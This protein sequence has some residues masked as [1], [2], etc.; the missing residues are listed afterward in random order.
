M[1]SVAFLWG[2]P[3]GAAGPESGVETPNLMTSSARALPGPKTASPT[4]ANSSTT[5]RER[6]FIAT[7][8]RLG[9]GSEGLAHADYRNADHPLSMGESCQGA[10]S[11][12][13]GYRRS[14]RLTTAR[15]A[16]YVTRAPPKG[17]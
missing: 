4:T 17:G 8:P 11:D 3:Q 2:I 15:A 9:I 16:A 5:R 6:D 12:A 10:A 7:P 13:V 1:S 14:P